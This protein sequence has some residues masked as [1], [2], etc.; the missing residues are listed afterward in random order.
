[1]LR[2]DLEA[3][4]Q[5]LIIP[6]YSFWQT[7]FFFCNSIYVTKLLTFYLINTKCL[8]NTK[9]QHQK[10]GYTKT[11]TFLL[12]KFNGKK[13]PCTLFNH[14]FT[15]CAAVSKKK[16]HTS[17]LIICAIYLIILFLIIYFNLWLTTKRNFNKFHQGLVDEEVSLSY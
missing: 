4:N 7:E 17:Y 9:Y 11:A 2:G 1:M 13:S 10:S 14:S 5:T 8:S 15:S 16:F 3:L 12:F 6:F